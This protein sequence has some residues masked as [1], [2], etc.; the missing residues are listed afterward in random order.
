MYCPRCSKEAL[1]SLFSPAH[2]M[3]E[4]TVWIGE[5]P[6]QY[7][8]CTNCGYIDVDEE[9]REDVEEFE[10]EYWSNDQYK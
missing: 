8:V 9:Y 6:I 1:F 5:T 4:Q 2:V 3:I 7:G 10:R